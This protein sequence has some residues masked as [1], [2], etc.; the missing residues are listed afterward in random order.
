LVAFGIPVGSSSEFYAF[1]GY[2]DLTSSSPF[3]DVNPVAPLAFDDL[4]SME[5]LDAKYSMNAAGRKALE[6]MVRKRFEPCYGSG[7][8]P[9]QCM[10]LS[11]YGFEYDRASTTFTAP[12]DVGTLA[13]T[14]EGTLTS[15]MING[16][17]K[18]IQ[19]TMKRDG[20]VVP[21]TGDVTVF[22]MVDIGKDP[23]VPLTK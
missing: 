1:P 10:P 2:L 13:Y 17:I 15:A 12:V 9:A 7:P 3:I 11:Y 5:V 6:D 8:K 20:Q 14:F 18:N 22:M 16:T 19:M 23:P 21:L 4:G